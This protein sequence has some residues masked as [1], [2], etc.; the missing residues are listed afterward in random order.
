MLYLARFQ[1][2]SSQS[3]RWQCCRLLGTRGGW[4]HMLRWWISQLEKQSFCFQFQEPGA[5]ESGDKPFLVAS[6]SLSLSFFFFPAVGIFCC[7]PLAFCSFLSLLLHSDA[8]FPLTS[9]GSLVLCLST[10]QGELL[11]LLLTS[12]HNPSPLLFL[13]VSC[14]CTASTFI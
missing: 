3:R 12:A 1:Q 14:T 4:I 11:F 7:H 8:L 5:K 2:L 6:L 13:P 9:K 10:F